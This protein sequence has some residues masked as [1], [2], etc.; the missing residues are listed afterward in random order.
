MNSNHANQSSGS[1]GSKVQTEDT[2]DIET[3]R[4]KLKMMIMIIILKAVVIQIFITKLESQANIC[5]GDS[6]GP[7]E[8]SGTSNRTGKDL[9]FN[10]E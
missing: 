6:H 5:L 9:V 8:K 10:I 2:A 1:P 4:K 7:S 3:L